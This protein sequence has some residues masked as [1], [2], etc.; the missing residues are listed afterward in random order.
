ML[1]S[2]YQHNTIIVLDYIISFYIVDAVQKRHHK[3]NLV[4]DVT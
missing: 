4:F 3:V 1:L 2:R